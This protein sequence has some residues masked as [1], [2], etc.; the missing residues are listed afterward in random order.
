M[1]LNWSNLC[2]PY[3]PKLALP[4]TPSNC[5]LL[6]W[7]CATLDPTP[8]DS[9]INIGRVFTLLGWDFIIHA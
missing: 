6:S 9:C 4:L 3:V 1:R 7:T 8:T 5:P 2:H